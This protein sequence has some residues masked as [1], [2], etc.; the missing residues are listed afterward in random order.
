MFE[1][2]EKFRKIVLVMEIVLVLAVAASTFSVTVA[3]AKPNNQACL[4]KDVSGYAQGG[5]D[6]GGFV[7]GLASAFQGVGEDIQAHLAGQVPDTVI[8]NS[9]ND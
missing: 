1:E 2:V 7:S 5:A 8:P 9:C 4:G 6:F 3:A